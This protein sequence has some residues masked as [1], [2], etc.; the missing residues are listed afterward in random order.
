MLI[1]F[2]AFDK[3]DHVVGRA[4]KDVAQMLQRMD[5]DAFV[6][7]HIVDRAGIKV[8]F[9]NQCISCNALFFH[10]LP[11]RFVTYH[12]FTSFFSN[13][14]ARAIRGGAC[15]AFPQLCS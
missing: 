9:C 6:V 13:S 10:K 12:V 15:G 1:L 14:S 8:V 4:V 2:A 3:L 5:G 11:K 7:L